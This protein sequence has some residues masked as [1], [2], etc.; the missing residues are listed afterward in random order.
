MKFG[1]YINEKKISIVDVKNFMKGQRTWF[2]LDSD[3]KDHVDYISR[4]YGDVGSETPGK[5]DYQEAMRL[6]TLLKK[7]FGNINTNVTDVDEWVYL[8]VT[9]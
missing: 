4:D 7:K 9:I 2:T 6:E 8:E 1:D 3:S 5:K